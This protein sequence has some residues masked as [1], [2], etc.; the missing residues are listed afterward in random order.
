MEINEKK[1]KVIRIGT[2][3]ENTEP[4]TD[5]VK[6]EYVT[7]FTLLGIDIDNKLKLMTE[8]FE[9]RKRKICQKIAIWRTLNLSLVGNLIVAKTFLISQLGYLLGMLECPKELLKEIRNDIDSFILRSRSHWV[10]KERIH[11]EPDKGGIGAINL[12]TYAT[13]LRYSWYKR[14]NKGLWSDKILDKAMKV[15]KVCFLKENDIPQCMWL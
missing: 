3:L 10:S 6:F 11:I 4:L 5:E 14:I 15:E 1:T 8:N 12:E 9:M 7:K 2:N 13:S